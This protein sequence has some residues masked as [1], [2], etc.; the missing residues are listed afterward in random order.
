[1]KTIGLLIITLLAALCV[2]VTRKHCMDKTLGKKSIIYFYNSICFGTAAIAL[3]TTG[4]FATV[5]LFTI[6]L[7]VLFGIVTALA[8]ISQS[9]ALT[10]GPMSYTSVI[11]SFA[12]LISA[13]SGVLFYDEKVGF[14]HIVGIILMLVSFAFAAEK[15]ENQKSANIKWLLLCITA[16]VSVGLIG[17]LQKIHQE[18]EFKAELNAFLVIAFGVS[19]AIC[20]ALAFTFRIKEKKAD[21]S[22]KAFEKS[23]IY[24]AI[25][26]GMCSATNNRIN[27]YLSGEMDSAVFFPIV[28]AGGLVLSILAAVLVFRERLSKKKMMGLILGILSVVVLY[29]PI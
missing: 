17:L 1:M 15:G 19:T 4:G 6:V 14:T 13:M 2:S 22:L 11:C 10:C 24:I 26:A 16:L 8:G 27:L 29:I 9:E 20:L 3:A 28:N 23:I 12:T 25:F 21:N 5:S 18:S 7:A